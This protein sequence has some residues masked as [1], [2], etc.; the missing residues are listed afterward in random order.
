MLAKQGLNETAEFDGRQNGLVTG[1]NLPSGVYALIPTAQAQPLSA[2]VWRRIKHLPFSEPGPR[3]RQNS[4][5]ERSATLDRGLT[6][7]ADYRLGAVSA[8]SLQ[9]TCSAP[10]PCHHRSSRTR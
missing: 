4:L 2:T 1:I 7:S 8:A 3:V 10:V 6:S 5:R 9:G